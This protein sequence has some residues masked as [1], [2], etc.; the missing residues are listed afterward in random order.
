VQYPVTW[1][2]FLLLLLG[3]FRR[4]PELENTLSFFYYSSDT[5]CQVFDRIE[6][7]DNSADKGAS[8]SPV[9]EFAENRS[10]R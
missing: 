5:K 10:N 7:Q 3:H 4:K 1:T 9:P 6:F 8:Y 2:F